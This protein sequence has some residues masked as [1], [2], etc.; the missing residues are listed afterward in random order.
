MYMD[1]SKSFVARIFKWVT[2]R[3]LLYK[4]IELD[5]ISASLYRKLIHHI[6]RSF[7][8]DMQCQSK[9]EVV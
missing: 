5:A 7:P 2:K 8:R 1:I 3:D 6:H 4:P 9:I